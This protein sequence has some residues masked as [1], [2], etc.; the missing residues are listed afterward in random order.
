MDGT[1]EDNEIFYR[2]LNEDENGF[3]QLR[4]VV[5]RLRGIEYLHLREYY[6]DFDGEWCPSP[7]GLA[8]P[9]DLNTVSELL[10]GLAEIISLAES[11]EIIKEYFGDIINNIYEQ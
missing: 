2:I 1:I 9:L 11:R 7:R 5:N 4:L 10:T 6:L 3:N 8:T